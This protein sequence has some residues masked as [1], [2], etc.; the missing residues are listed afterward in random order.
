MTYAKQQIERANAVNLADFLRSQGEQLTKSGKY[1]RWNAHDS[2]TVR[3]NKWYRHSQSRGRGGYP[4]SFVM[5]FYNRTFPEAVELLIREKPRDT[6][7]Q[8]EPS[9][10]L[11]VPRRNTDNQAAI[12]YLTNERSLDSDVVGAFVQSGDI[13]EDAATTM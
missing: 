3:E 13:Y 4:V 2:M 10:E 5:E 7:L 6:A 11:R 9:P 1:Y 12:E 8:G